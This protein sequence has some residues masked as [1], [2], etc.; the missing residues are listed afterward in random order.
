MAH[1]QI[2]L[3]RQEVIEQFATEP[4]SNA[5]PNEIAEVFERCLYI[6][7][8]RSP[9]VSASEPSAESS[10]RLAKWHKSVADRAY[11]RRLRLV[12]VAMLSVKPSELAESVRVQFADAI[13]DYADDALPA[14]LMLIGR[15]PRLW[16]DLPLTQRSRLSTCLDKAVYHIQVVRGAWEIEELRPVVFSKVDRDTIAWS[17]DF[18]PDLAPPPQW[19]P[20]ALKALQTSRS[21]NQSDAIVATLAA[22][23]KSLTDRHI[24]EFCR[25]AG[26]NREVAGKGVW[27]FV[28]KLKATRGAAALGSLLL[29]DA[30]RYPDWLIKDLVD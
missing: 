29:P 25:T 17:A 13:S 3:R 18:E 11:L 15:L 5:P 24:R 12:L 20:F 27:R 26:N 4:I 23:M 2:C 8:R 21:W 28:E 16:L 1:P 19:I 30:E 9:C 6:H 22:N 14:A 10:N 7:R